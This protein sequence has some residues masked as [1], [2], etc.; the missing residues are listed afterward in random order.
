MRKQPESRRKN[1]AKQP[2]GLGKCFAFR[3]SFGRGVA[4]AWRGETPGIPTTQRL[5]GQAISSLG[6]LAI[7]VSPGGHSESTRLPTDRRCPLAR[8]PLPVISEHDDFISLSWIPLKSRRGPHT[9]GREILVAASITPGPPPVITVKP[10]S[11]SAFP[12][13]LASS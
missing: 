9:V 12:I 1:G 7:L 10:F 3:H 5:Q 4:V 8:L 11:A 2:S 6:K 13:L